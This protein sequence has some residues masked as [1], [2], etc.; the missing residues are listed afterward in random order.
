MSDRIGAL[1]RKIGALANRVVADFMGQVPPPDVS[2]RDMCWTQLQAVRMQ[3]PTSKKEKDLF[4]AML[5]YLKSLPNFEEYA[6]TLALVESALFKLTYFPFWAVRHYLPDRQTLLDIFDAIHVL[7]KSP[8]MM[9]VHQRE[10]SL[11]VRARQLARHS[12]IEPSQIPAMLDCKSQPTLDAIASI[13]AKWSKG[14]LP[15]KEASVAL[16]NVL[17]AN[18]LLADD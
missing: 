17:D 12:L 14:I 7:E 15:S 3:P 9:K 10:D 2:D 6:I 18:N 16:T 4:L 13:Q 8:D 1:E 5:A 11:S